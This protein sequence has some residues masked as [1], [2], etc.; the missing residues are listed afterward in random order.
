MNDQCEA[1]VMFTISKLHCCCDLATCNAEVANAKF[2]RNKNCQPGVFLVR[3][4]HSSSK[5]AGTLP[6]LHSRSQ[7]CFCIWI[8]VLLLITL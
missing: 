6:G 3:V 1:V 2:V 8:N 7:F 5:V 4:S